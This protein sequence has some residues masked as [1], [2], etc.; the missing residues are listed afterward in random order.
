MVVAVGTVLLFVLIAIIDLMFF[1]FL[2]KY[3]RKVASFILTG[4]PNYFDD[5]GNRR[6]S[7]IS[8]LQ[9]IN[10]QPL[11]N[12]NN[13]ANNKNSVLKKSQR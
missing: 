1:G 3:G 9:R 13:K 8:N 11:I 5:N 4:D 6:R 2:W 10:E 7:P 12:H